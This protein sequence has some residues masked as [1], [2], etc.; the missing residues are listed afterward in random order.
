ME[1]G[2]EM[3]ESGTR[4]DV[5]SAATHELETKKDEPTPARLLGMVVEALIEQ[6]RVN[7]ERARAGLLEYL[8]EIEGTEQQGVVD[9]EVIAS[10]QNVPRR[11]VQAAVGTLTDAGDIVLNDDFSYS[12]N[13]DRRQS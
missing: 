4:E 6:E 9:T 1:G 3:Q 13:P 11:E 2:E 5:V 7:S 8:H 12:L 10:R